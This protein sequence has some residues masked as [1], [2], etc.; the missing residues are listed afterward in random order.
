MRNLVTLL[1]SIWVCTAQGQTPLQNS[2]H[3][4][5]QQ[6]IYRIT[7]AEAQYI[8]SKGIRPG[9]AEAYLHTLVDSTP[10]NGVLPQLGAGHYLLAHA[11]E[12]SLLL[13]L[14]PVANNQVK[15][16]NNYR[17]LAVMVHDSMGN[18]LPNAQVTLRKKHLHFDA[19]TQ[20]YRLNRF[21]K[22]GL[23]KV[24]YNRATSFYPLANSFHKNRTLWQKIKW[25]FPLKYISN[26]LRPK[27]KYRSRHN[28]FSGTVP[29]QNNFHAYFVYSKPRY[30]PG[31]TVRFK[32]YILPKK[33][34]LVDRPLLLRLSNRDLD[35]DTI[36]ATVQPYRAGGYEGQLVLN[37]SLDLDL[38]DD[39]LLTLEE[40]SSRK[41]NLDDYDGDLDDDEYVLQ[42]KVLAKGIFAYEEYE[43]D[44]VKFTARADKSNHGPGNHVAVFAKATD[45]NDLP[46]ADGRLQ[47]TLLRNSVS[48]VYMPQLFIPD[49]LWQH[50]L[51]LDPVGETKI[52]LPD[53]IFPK[54]DF[55]Y[56]IVV[57]FLNS[58]NEEQV[59]QLLQQYRFSSHR[60]VFKPKQDSLQISYQHN[61][62]D[63]PKR[64]T[65]AL[66]SGRSNTMQQLS[67]TL[68]IT[69]PISPFMESCTVQ[70]DSVQE[71]YVVQRSTAA[72]NFYTNRTKDSVTIQTT[73]PNR[74][75]FW[76]TLMAG[77]KV[78]EKGYTNNLN[79]AQK[80]VTP[81]N[82]F[83]LLQYIWAGKV[84]SQDY[85]IPYH[86]KTLSI[87]VEQPATVFPGQQSQI[88]LLVKDAAGKPVADADVTGWSFTQK[89]EK[90][91]TPSMP[92]TSK[93]YG[94]FAKKVNYLL[95]A[96]PTLSADIQLNWQRWS[97][98]MALDSIAY[99]Q[100]LH[101]TPIY[102]STVP[103]VD[104]ITQLAP[105]VVKNG[106]LQ[107]IHL[108]YIDERP[109]FF[110][111][112]E[113]MQ[114]YSF[115]VKPGKHALRLRTHNSM[116]HLDSV[117]IQPGA[118]NII[119]IESG[120]V[121]KGLSTTAQ[122]DSLTRY[123]QQLWSKYMIVVQ[124]KYGE[125][126][127]TIAQDSTLYQ[128]PPFSPYNYN[129]YSYNS[130]YDR[131]VG[132]LPK[133]YA[134]L[135]VKRQFEQ[136]FTPEPQYSFNIE[137]GL[138]KQKSLSRRNPFS[139]YLNN[140]KPML[141]FGQRVLTEEQVD[142]LWQD[143][144][145]TRAHTTEIYRN[146]NFGSSNVEI[147]VSKWPDGREVFV[148]TIFLFRYDN[149]DVV[150]VYKGQQRFLGSLPSGYYRMMLLLKS[151]QYALYDSILVKDHGYNYF[152]TGIVYP[153][154]KDSM[155]QSM[156][157]I[158]DSWRKENYYQNFYADGDRIK[159]TFNIQYFNTQSFTNTINGRIIDEKGA[160][161]A[162]AVVKV[163]GLAM[164][165]AADANGFFAIRTPQSGTLE[166]SA[167]GYQTVQ[168]PI[169]SNMATVVMPQSQSMLSEVVVTGYGVVKKRSLSASMVTVSGDNIQQLQARVPGVRITN[170][171][172]LLGNSTKVTL[173]GANS[174]GE[175]KSPLYV[176]DGVVYNGTFADFDA[177]SIVSVDVLKDGS[178]LYGAAGA[179]GVIV[180]TTNKGTRMLLD[181]LAA[182]TTETAA[183]LP[184][185]LRRHFKD[186]G[187]WQPRLRTDAQGKASF[188]VTFPDD[189]TKWRT[190]YAA[191]TDKKQTGLTELAIRSYKPL[192]A[193]LALPQFL[194]Q[195][196][197]IH[198]IGKVL[199]YNSDTATAN[200][201]FFINDNLI[202]QASISVANAKIDTFGLRVATADSIKLKYTIEQ[203]GGYFDGE[204]RTVP[205]FVQGITETQGLF[206]VLDSDTSFTLPAFNKTAPI[207]V[208]AEASVLPVLLDEI[209]KVKKYEYLCNEQLA[210]KLK[211]LLLEKKIRQQ[212]GQ[213]FKEEKQIKTLIEKLTQ[214]RGRNYMWG[215]W[216][217]NDPSLWITLHV[218]EALLQAETMGYIV[219]LAKQPIIDYLVYNQASFYREDKVR[220]LLLLQQLQ[221]KADFK[222]YADSIAKHIKPTTLYQKLQWIAAQQQLGLPVNTDSVLLWSSR[223][224]MG[225]LYWGEEGYR[226]FD[227]A[228]QNTLLAYA[229]L[230][231][232]GGQ[233][234]L[235]KKMRYYF[236]EK[237][238]SGQWRNTYESA[239][240]LETILPDLLAE[241]GV[242]QPPSFTIGGTTNLTVKDFPFSWQA[243]A[244]DSVTIAK[245][246]GLP[247]YF[248]AYQQYHNP[249]P[250][251]VNSDFEVST[252]FEK[253]G[254][255]LQQL[256][257]G[258]AVQ[259]K[260][261][262]TVKADADYVMV[263]IPI[264]AG[265][266]YKSKQQGY[267]NNEVHREHF[268][269]K[270]SLFC[271]ALKKGSYTFTVELLPRY[272][273]LY[274]LN[275]AKAEMMYFPVFYGREGMKQ[276]V[277]R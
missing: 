189:I 230:R 148:K 73:N 23:L 77:N 203:S 225:N 84:Q 190:F 14:H 51:P 245:K 123:E 167:V 131:L 50:N 177:N 104:S 182:T 59:K 150:Q 68:P 249:A 117:W 125:D 30:K 133:N 200:R 251:K 71:N 93:A 144:L 22:K 116:I 28:Y 118:K 1:L 155:S 206:A 218:T 54:A 111:Q 233:E 237:R 153:K 119:S 219:M 36:L 178:A 161:I 3:T 186:D 92:F 136:D 8:I 129:S 174:I 181:S 86:N 146:R 96:P 277:I 147:A 12:N 107:P 121:A 137:K 101:P 273:G 110:S 139:S 268:K 264:P 157:D 227:N 142:S 152:A 263:E 40:L 135:K 165:A 145:D 37:D 132:P 34:K 106:D 234:A 6:Y 168:R 180:V 49:T 215:W 31:D 67:A 32:A 63:K 115:A 38:D 143:Y 164:G 169:G 205:V 89:F 56:T 53:S 154:A 202:Q 187:F 183:A 213:P 149:P 260:T 141:D 172:G 83:L 242:N 207:T 90:A 98:E 265:C 221:A 33:S 238:K 85:Y 209:D 127:A 170:G 128:L 140:Q 5:A 171:L 197:S 269:N 76:Y 109:V 254:Q 65:I 240:I 27:R 204:E 211:C 163:K 126:F 239:L 108:L 166:F 39:Y 72:I 29:Y 113:Q 162:F 253:N 47:V 42:R 175:L 198:L 185:T 267:A 229:I 266:S 255:S 26:W 134:Q 120:G 246:A 82:Y 81:K 195:G 258:E 226:F 179:N 199:N 70:T 25:S 224:M 208:H 217:E 114:R 276:V 62:E 61:G 193:N 79:I 257:A 214:N 259:L 196:D 220:S 80:T 194:V 231:K 252:V 91:P 270:V 13:S 138:I 64:A 78:I 4:S 99:F 103:M 57:R 69:L 130:P 10:I 244:T 124:N 271:T 16:I 88:N 188:T 97:K 75:F 228:V 216:A 192:S 236:L 66:Q 212:M 122:P 262:V 222:T 232:R 21:R 60:L 159:E 191:M 55:N 11:Q 74:L 2:L 151:G 15:I 18:I 223:T 24:Q 102:Q 7:D 94:G 201:K 52:A 241:V 156:N 274:H 250:K 176:V 48:A 256:K 17:N 158:V 44:Q 58:N 105:F 248:T 95:Q 9:K 184:N 261:T 247:V 43:L 87:E 41:Y 19:A 210:S 100:F 173:R 20:T 46:I 35:I 45:E 275:P 235:L 243:N 272:N 112:A 160:P